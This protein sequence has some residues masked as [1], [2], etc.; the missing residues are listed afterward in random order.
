MGSDHWGNG[1]GA[2]VNACALPANA[3]VAAFRHRASLLTA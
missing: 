1:S 2:N 3:K